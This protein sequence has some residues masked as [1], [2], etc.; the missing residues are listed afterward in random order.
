VREQRQHG[1]GEQYG[2]AERGQFT[3]VSHCRG[4]EVLGR[5]YFGRVRSAA[6]RS[7]STTR[8]AKVKAVIT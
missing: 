8:V 2:G 7:S 5:G 4:A 3:R 6:A 1:R